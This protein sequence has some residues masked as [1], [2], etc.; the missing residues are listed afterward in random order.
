MSRMMD[1]LSLWGLFAATVV[2][3]LLSIEAGYQL[4]H[5]RRRSSGDEKEAPVGAIVAATL[6]LL[7]FILAFTFGM[8]ASRFDARRQVVVEEANAIG[9]TY[10]RAGLLPDGRAAK[11]RGLLTEYVDV[12]LKAAQTG[13][14]DEALRRSDELHRQ[15]WKEAEAVGQQHPNSIVV[16]LFIQAL[17]ETI[18]VHAK[19]ILVA[20][21]SRVPGALWG[22]LYL[23]TIL[24]MTG[25]GYYEGLAN[26]RRSPAIL[27][28]V[29]TFSAIIMLVVDLDRPS[30]GLLQVSQQAMVDVRNMMKE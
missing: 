29:S 16:G 22:T 23:I 19:R 14:I 7:G 18:D 10:L 26:S 1:A 17:N 3:V 25:V 6:A 4:G 30:E 5:Y 20:V 21:E 9:T 13:N 24:T 28:L 15:L 11:I 8:A 27:V 2:A 12:R